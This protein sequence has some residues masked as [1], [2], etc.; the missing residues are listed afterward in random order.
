MKKI[1][2]IISRVPI[3]SGLL[4]NQLQEIRKIAVDRYVDKGEIIFSE[5]DEGNGFFV[6][7]DGRI[8][9]FKASIEGK[10]QILHIL[11]PGEPFGQVAVFTGKPFPANAQAIA[12]SRLLFFPRTEFVDLI[13]GNASLSLNMLAAL[14]MRLQDFTVQVGD[15]SLKDAPGRLA[16]YLLFMADEQ[17]KGDYVTLNISKLQLA[18]LLGTIPETLS[19][20]FS[21]MTEQDLIKV[22]GRTITLV[23]CPGLERLAE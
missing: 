17:G 10:E 20:T 22:D 12:K 3:F 14:S 6:I 2:D 9:I 18:H 7:T 19:R 23:N 4:E 1:L 11:G 13:S 21:K 16:S 5:G 8:K 15:L